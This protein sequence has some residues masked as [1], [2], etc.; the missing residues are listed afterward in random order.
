MIL[1]EKGINR[2]SKGSKL[3]EVIKM[4]DIVLAGGCFWGVEAYLARI[5]GVIGTEVG[6]A[7]GHVKNPT[8]EDVCR[9]DT[10]HAEVCYV[11][12]DERII[13][14]E[15]LL[16]RFWKIIDPTVLN[17]QGPDI[18]SQY[19]TGIYYTNT[20]DIQVVQDSMKRQ[21]MEYERPIVTE[22]EPLICFYKAEAY[23]QKY[24]EKNPGGYCHIDLNI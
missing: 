11:K 2:I 17:R 14:L 18:G 21:Q 9:R 20:E 12:Y 22:I 4:K 24:L 8:Y 6:Y 13:T 5:E 7:N 16:E 3:L 23:H 15:A 19:R 10:G 1:K